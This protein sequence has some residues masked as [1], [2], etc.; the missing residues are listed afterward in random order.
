[1]STV[2]RIV[3]LN[4]DSFILVLDAWGDLFSCLILLRERM[5]Q[6]VYGNKEAD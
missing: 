1:M 4:Y 5:N 3:Q 2:S 6:I